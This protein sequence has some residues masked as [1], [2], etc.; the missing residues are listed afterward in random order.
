MA[1]NQFHRLFDYCRLRH[2]QIN[3]LTFSMR[4]SSTFHKISKQRMD[5]KKT[6]NPV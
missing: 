4:M 6:L 2:H 5:E 1:K 3:A